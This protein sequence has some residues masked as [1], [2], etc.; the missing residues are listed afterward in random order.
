MRTVAIVPAAGSGNR[1]GRELS[2]QYL[3]LGGMPLLVRTLKV[4]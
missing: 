1:M 2:K 4:Y 3:S